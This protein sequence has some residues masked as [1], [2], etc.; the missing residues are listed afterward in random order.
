MMRESVFYHGTLRPEVLGAPL[1]PAQDHPWWSRSSWRVYDSWLTGGDI[2]DASLPYANLLWHQLG[3]HDRRDSLHPHLKPVRSFAALGRAVSMIFVTDDPRHAG[4]Y[5]DVHE[6]YAVPEDAIAIVS[7]PN[8][9][10]SSAW[11]LVV[12]AGSTLQVERGREGP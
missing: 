5:G 4:R 3:L 2:G 10:T 9:R 8:I 12:K 6:V 7:D 1:P 11:I